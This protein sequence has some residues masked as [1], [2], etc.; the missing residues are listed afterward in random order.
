MNTKIVAE[1]IKLMD[2]ANLKLIEVCEGEVKIR[3]EK[4]TAEFA[5]APVSMVH[6]PAVKAEAVSKVDAAFKSE[7]INFNK[8]NEVRSPLVG[9]FYAAPSPDSPPFVKIGQK[10]KK[11]DVLCIVEA[12]K[13][14][15]EINAEVDG[16]VADV[17]V[18]NGDII[19]YNQILFKI[20]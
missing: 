5:S 9:V 6:I 8:L 2:T 1:L 20:F 7:V 11:G 17:C 16:E 10:V 14:M 12:M 15:N 13:Q 19:E 4:N 18:K 3:L